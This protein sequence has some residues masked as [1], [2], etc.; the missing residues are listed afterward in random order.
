MTSMASPW[1]HIGVG[2]D[3]GATGGEYNPI[4]YRTDVFN[5]VHEET[6]WLSQTPDTPSKSWD[7][8]SNRIVTIGVFDHI[9][10]GRRFIHANTHL[11]NANAVA[12]TNQIGVAVDLIKAVD[13]AYGPNLPI[14]LTGDFN[15]GNTDAAYTTLVADNYVQDMYTMANSSQRSENFYTYTGFSNEAAD[16][17]DYIWLGPETSA[18]Y[19]V[20]QYQVLDNLVDGVK[21]SDHRPVVGDV[22][23]G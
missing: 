19:K 8:G 13:A 14:S 1:A 5:V 17:I 18:P 23:L 21:I 7:S 15:S 20:N 22:T 11:D 3:D 4:I 10:T 12:R 9:A 6:K 2:R 16:R